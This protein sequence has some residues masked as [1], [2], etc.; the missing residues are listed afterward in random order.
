MNY[1]AVHL[2]LTQHCKSTI[3]QTKIFFKSLP[4]YKK[5]LANCVVYVSAQ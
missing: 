2:K 3:F 5:E 4:P 1:F